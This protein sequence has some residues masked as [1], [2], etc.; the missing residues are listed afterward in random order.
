MALFVKIIYHYV[1]QP[2]FAA[3]HE[4]TSKEAKIAD[5]VGNEE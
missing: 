2:M 4:S 1:A 5:V 3:N